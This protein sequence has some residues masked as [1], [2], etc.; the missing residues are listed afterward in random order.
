[1]DSYVNYMMERLK[2]FGPDG[3]LVAGILQRV[4]RE[5]EETECRV[6]G[7]LRM[8]QPALQALEEHDHMGTPRSNVEEAIQKLDLSAIHDLADPD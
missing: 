6:G 3:D 4:K 7:M 1:M 8:I 5:I 2:T